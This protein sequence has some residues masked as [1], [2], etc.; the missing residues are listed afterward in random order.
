MSSNPEIST[1]SPFVVEKDR[2][3]KFQNT[4]SFFTELRT[5][6]P[7][8][9][10]YYP[11]PG[12]DDSLNDVFSPSEM[13][14]IDRT[15]HF[16]NITQGDFRT[17]NFPSG[18]FD[19]VFIQDIHEQPKDI[20]EFVRILRKNGI[21]V[22]GLYGCGMESRG[23]TSFDYVLQLPSLREE[24]LLKDWSKLFRTFRKV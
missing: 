4:A 6:E 24:E 19:A 1:G 12:L 20:A 17:V 10:V 18:K 23:S 15:P 16:K 21:L 5:V 9:S 7:I 8:N 14:Y 22:Y 11:G 13:T 2:L 3:V